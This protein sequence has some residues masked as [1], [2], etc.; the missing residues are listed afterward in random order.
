MVGVVDRMEGVS[1]LDQA[2]RVM[3]GSV[4]I[5]GRMIQKRKRRKQLL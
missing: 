2:S 3:D 5:S 4:V 1:I